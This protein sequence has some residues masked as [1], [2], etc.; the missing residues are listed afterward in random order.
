MKIEDVEKAYG[1]KHKIV[2]TQN[3]IEQL[4]ES[5]CFSVTGIS[6]R[7]ECMFSGLRVGDKYQSLVFTMVMD[8]LQRVLNETLAEL[9][10]L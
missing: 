8:E 2:E 1:L 4:R 10:K 5:K 9:E 7:G 3:R 6:E